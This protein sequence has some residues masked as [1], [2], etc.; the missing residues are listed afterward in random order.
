M[1]I[2]AQRDHFTVAD[3]E[4]V[5]D[6]GMRYEVVNGSLFVTP[7]AGY[8]HNR[9]AQHIGLALLRAAPAELAVLMTG[10]QAVALDGGDGPCPDVL[11]FQ[12]GDY[13]LAVP[14]AAVALVV[15]VTS[16]S[17]RSND[18]VTKLERYARAGIPHY[19]IV[20][21]DRIAV[22]ELPPGSE[23]YR[24]VQAGRRVHVTAPFPVDVALPA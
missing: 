6:D 8:P 5:P 18:T 21:P 7:P 10:T 19:W 9:R 14:V 3:L 22:Y 20:D 23:R 17:N 4:R 2:P 16:P 11:V 13:S 1:S 12:P 15:E 24:E